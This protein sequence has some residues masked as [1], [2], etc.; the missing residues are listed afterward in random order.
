MTAH[1]ARY[2]IVAVALALA[3]SAAAK[4]IAHHAF[5]QGVFQ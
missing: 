2:I 1:D 3:I 4:V 5:T